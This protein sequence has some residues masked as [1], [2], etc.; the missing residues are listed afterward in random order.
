MKQLQSVWQ[1][2]DHFCNAI[3]VRLEFVNLFHAQAFDAS[4]QS[5]FAYHGKL[6]FE[7]RLSKVNVPAKKCI[8]WR[9]NVHDIEL[10]FEMTWQKLSI[11]KCPYKKFYDFFVVEIDCMHSFIHWVW[12]ECQKRN[13]KKTERNECVAR[14][15]TEFNHRYVICVAF[16][17]F[18]CKTVNLHGVFC[19]WRLN[20]LHCFTL[21]STIIMRIVFIQWKN[22]IILHDNMQNNRERARAEWS[23]FVRKYVCNHFRNHK[24][25]DNLK[26]MLEAI[27]KQKRLKS[28]AK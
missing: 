19:R 13:E 17:R 4:K 22:E 18:L 24:L 8:C 9:L 20:E 11:R 14:A 26:R 10:S 12:I 21:R 7:M 6:L 28:K 23:S 27:K 16:E 2:L 25:G 3:F 5:L 1:Y 15:T